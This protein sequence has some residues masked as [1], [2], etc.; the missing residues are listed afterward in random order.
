MWGHLDGIKQDGS[1]ICT[2]IFGNNMPTSK[3]CEYGYTLISR[4]T[5]CICSQS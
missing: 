2:N 4:N 1:E 3:N 5:T